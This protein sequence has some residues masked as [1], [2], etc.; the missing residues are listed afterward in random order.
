MSFFWNSFCWGTKPSTRSLGGGCKEFS[1]DFGAFRREAQAVLAPPELLGYRFETKSPPV[2][3]R[4]AQR[5]ATTLYNA[6]LTKILNGNLFQLWAMYQLWAPGRSQTITCPKSR[7][8]ILVPIYCSSTS[9]KLLLANN[10]GF[11][12]ATIRSPSR[13]VGKSSSESPSD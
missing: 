13:A 11:M 5:N 7:Q 3:A 12:S 10:N 6:T 8:I 1:N 2:W 4:C 9:Y